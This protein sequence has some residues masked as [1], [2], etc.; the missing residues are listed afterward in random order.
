MSEISQNVA[1]LLIEDTATDAELCIRTLKKQNIANE[2]VWL[3]D[4]AEALAY[5]FDVDAVPRR[6]PRLVLLDLHLPK[7]H[8][9]EVLRR[10]KSDERTRTIPVVVLTSS[11]EDR[12]IV[13]SYKF[14]GNSYVSKPVEFAAFVTTISQLGLYWLITNHPLHAKD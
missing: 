10:I 9:L 14:G 12:D 5:L 6:V 1:V 13:E 2:I 11:K 4:G 8:G 7:V 3:K